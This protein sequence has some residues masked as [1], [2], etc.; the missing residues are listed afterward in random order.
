[1]DSAW[2]RYDESMTL[3]LQ[4]VTKADKTVRSA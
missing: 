1:M 2:Q 4:K 3:L